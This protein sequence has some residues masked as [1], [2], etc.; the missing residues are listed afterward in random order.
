[1]S[2][3]GRG[4]V[5]AILVL[6]F[7]TGVTLDR[8]WDTR[9]R[10]PRGA[11]RQDSPAPSSESAVPVRRYFDPDAD[12]EVVI[13]LGGIRIPPAPR[14]RVVPRP[15]SSNR[16]PVFEGE[17]AAGAGLTRSGDPGFSPTTDRPTTDRRTQGGRSQGGGASRRHDGPD[18][19]LEEPGNDLEATGRETQREPIRHTVLANE[20]LSDIALQYLGNAGAWERIRTL[21]GISDPTQIRAG[22]TLLIPVD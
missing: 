18:D 9:A 3:M 5:L 16:A 7:L 6:I 12:T 21:N 15:G 8:F 19:R 10:M 13:R 4:I 1:M 2:N 17:N 22:Q 20:T 11:L 14:E